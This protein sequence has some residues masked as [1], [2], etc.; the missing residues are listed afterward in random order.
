MAASKTFVLVVF[1]RKL[2]T[3]QSALQFLFMFWFL[4]TENLT[5]F[6]HLYKSIFKK[7]V[8]FRSHRWRET[9]LPYN[10]KHPRTNA[11]ITVGFDL[12]Q[13]SEILSRKSSAS[14]TGSLDR[15]SDGGRGSKV[16]RLISG[17]QSNNQIAS[18]VKAKIAMFSCSSSVSGGGTKC[19]E[20][21]KS[22]SSLTRSLTHNDVRYEENSQVKNNVPKTIAAYRSMVN[23]NE[24]SSANSHS[25]SNLINKVSTFGNGR[26]Q[27]LMEIGKKT[28]TVKNPNSRSFSSNGLLLDHRDRNND[29][30]SNKTKLKGL[31]IPES[32]NESPVSSTASSATKVLTTPPWKS[33][34]DNFPKYSPAFK[35]KPFVVYS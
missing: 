28:E 15:N 11:L 17:Q 20:T 16:K 5:G 1:P 4:S 34:S 23:V 12:F 3:D 8:I 10:I 32:S 14:S 9:K 13:N 6:L 19:S 29:R 22:T 7:K 27:S 2:Q 26:S 21:S 24:K 18:S 31:V 30:M 25:A 33:S 35:R